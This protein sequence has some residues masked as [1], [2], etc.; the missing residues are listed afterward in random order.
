[1]R[2][3]LKDGEIT[4]YMTICIPESHKTTL[5]KIA[6]E[7]YIPTSA[8]VREFIRKGIKEK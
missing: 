6:K 7:R 8:L 4:K 1:M 3:K 2:N 5:E